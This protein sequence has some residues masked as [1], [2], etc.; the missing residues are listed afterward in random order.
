MAY[1]TN[2]ISNCISEV[3][4]TSSYYNGAC[5]TSGIVQYI[6]S[7]G[8]TTISDCVVMGT[9]TATTDEGKKG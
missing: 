9:F 3:N 1:G 7:Y 8:N 2:S 6:D 4:I 5:G